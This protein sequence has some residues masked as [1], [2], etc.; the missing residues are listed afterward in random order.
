MTFKGL[1]FLRRLILEIETYTERIE[2]DFFQRWNQGGEMKENNFGA[3]KTNQRSTRL[4]CAFI[5]PLFIK[6][7]KSPQK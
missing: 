6:R 2:K 7:E 5:L 3:S 1:V 4:I